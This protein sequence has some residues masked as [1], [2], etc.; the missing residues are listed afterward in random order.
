MNYINYM[1]IQK[2]KLDFSKTNIID[3]YYVF[4]KKI[5][6]LEDFSFL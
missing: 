3:K 6:F 1:K 4:S 2:Y 5:L